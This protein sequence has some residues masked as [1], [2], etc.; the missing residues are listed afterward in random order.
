MQWVLGFFAIILLYH[1]VKFTE[2]RQ[3]IKYND[4]PNKTHV[5]IDLFDIEPQLELAGVLKNDLV[6]SVPDYSPN[7]SLYLMNRK[8][9]T[10]FN[11]L[12]LSQDSVKKYLK[13][14]YKYIVVNRSEELEQDYL[15]PF[16][17]EEILQKGEV[18]VF[19]AKLP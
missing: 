16:L 4:W 12:H 11:K 15:N 2:Q 3:W 1:N 5:S 19:K 6:I 8:G 18:A 7:M 14:N 13:L 17:G 9:V 10:N